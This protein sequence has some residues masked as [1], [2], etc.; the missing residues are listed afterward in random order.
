AIGLLVDNSIVVMENILRYNKL[1]FDPVES[2]RRGAEEVGLAITAA[3]LTTIVVF[4]PVFYMEVSELNIY[5]REFSIPV[6]VS[7]AASLVVSLT[8]IPLAASRLRHLGRSH[9]EP[10]GDAGR[11]RRMYRSIRGRFHP[12]R[13]L[14]S[15]YIEALDWAV[16]WRL[17]C[18]VAVAVLAVVTFLIP[19]RRVGMQTLPSVDWRRVEIRVRLAQN[20]DWPHAERIFKAIE[21]VVDSQR[22]RLGVQNIYV[23]PGTRGGIV[24]VYLRRSGDGAPG[25]SSLC[26]TE[27]VGAILREQLPTLLPGGEINIDVVKSAGGAGARTAEVRV[28]GEDIRL[29]TEYA[30]RFKYLMA[31]LPDVTE[32]TTDL[33]AG[34]EEIQLRIDEPL[35]AE[36]GIPALGVARAVDFALRGTRV[37]YMKDG[38]EEVPVKARLQGDDRRDL[39]DLDNVSLV[40]PSGALV[41][42]NRL[43][44]KEKAET[45]GALK[46]VDGKNVVR[47]V[48]NVA[49]DDLAAF[50]RQLEGLIASFRMERGYEIQQG[51]RLD[52]LEVSARNF[53]RALVM[54]IVL[55]YL[56]MGAL[57]ES[58]L[59]PLSILTSVPL[60]FIGV[61][62]SMYLTDTSMDII[63]LIGAILMCGVVVNNAIVLVDHIN[64]LRKQGRERRDAVL[65]AGRDRSRPVMMTALTTILGCLPLA[66]GAGIGDMSFSSLGRTLI[67]GLTASTLLT[68]FVVPV[69]YTLIDDLRAWFLAFFGD[70]ARARQR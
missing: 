52:E 20:Y 4:I 69:F 49:T 70:V 42:I 65:Q 13:W 7:L 33:D 5:M 51:E 12:L 55:I 21:S 53:T 14:I 37:F 44:R 67:G 41:P 58:Y 11:L 27:E 15:S 32:V 6:T 63:S 54:A 10:R 36:E 68:L 23:S 34:D 60:A 2:A 47:V 39:G 22:E 38:I 9:D 16:R 46:R 18:V 1:G 31:T 25:E 48:A 50:K 28:C 57:F 61:Y 3:T 19:F 66:I 29:L 62:W 64:L 17:A 24:R 30:E 40:S 43:V 26:T 59:L 45:P 35:A 56:V 8:V